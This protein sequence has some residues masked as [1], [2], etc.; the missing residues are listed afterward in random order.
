[1]MDI[2]QLCHDEFRDGVSPG[3]AARQMCRSLPQGSAVRRML[4]EM[5]AK[6]NRASFDR[7]CILRA[8]ED[9]D[10]EA[11]D[12]ARVES[13]HRINQTGAENAPAHAAL[14]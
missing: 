12:A 8:F 5:L 7:S 9:C 13:F 10:Q 2:E 11:A 1:M 4:E 6:A 3:A 14:H